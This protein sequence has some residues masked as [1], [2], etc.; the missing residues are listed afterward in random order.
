[1]TLIWS[2]DITVEHHL[3][4]IM[5]PHPING[6]SGGGIMLSESL[7]WEKKLCTCLKS[8]FPLRVFSNF[9]R[10]LFILRIMFSNI[11]SH[12]F[13]PVVLSPESYMSKMLFTL[14][15]LLPPST[16]K[17]VC[18]CVCVYVCV[19]RG[20]KNLC[21]VLLV[22]CTVIFFLRPCVSCTPYL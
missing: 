16:P 11:F 20:L 14:K 7:R 12:K 22:Y 3:H 10:I 17:N 8:C 6:G 4:V 18:V 19:G 1:M 15:R 13:I 2:S 5:I 9:Q 21:T